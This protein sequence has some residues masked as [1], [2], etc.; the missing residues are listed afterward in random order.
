MSINNV[1]IIG[2]KPMIINQKSTSSYGVQ[3]AGNSADGAIYQFNDGN[4]S[5]AFT[6][7]ER[8]AAKG[9]I[10]MGDSGDTLTLS[11]GWHSKGY[12]QNQTPNMGTLAGQLFEDG[13]GHQLL[14][15]GN[16]KLAG[17]VTGT[18]DKPVQGAGGDQGAAY[19]TG[20]K[21]QLNKDIGAIEDSKTNKPGGKVDQL[22]TKDEINNAIKDGAFDGNQAKKTFWQKIADNF[23]KYDTVWKDP[24]TGGENG[25]NDH[26]I[27]AGDVANGG[28][29]DPA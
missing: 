29:I 8:N 20:N 11:G 24:F 6:Y 12:A 21:E 14:V 13:N 5:D 28:E 3:D 16:V 9:A 19:S 15:S 1:N 4:N 17:D 22:V 7:S 27:N 18:S 10:F 26:V 25:G 23:G 2:A